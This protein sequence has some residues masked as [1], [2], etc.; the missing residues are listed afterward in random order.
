MSK[1]NNTKQAFWIALGSLF[2]FGFG[3]VS[4]MILSRYFDKADYGT[5]KQV[6]Y[7]YHTLLTVFTLGLPKAFSY[8]LPRVE[9]NQAKNLIKKITNLFFILGAVFSVILFVFAP[10][11][12]IILKNPDLKIALR[13]FSLVP[14]LM[15]PTMGLEGILSTYR[16]TKFMAIY[17]I[18]TRVI[19][20]LC[21]ALPVIIFNLG[22][23]EALIGFTIAS[24]ISF[25]IALYFKYLPVKNTGND[26]CCI[27]YKEIFKFSIPLLY[28]SIWGIIIT[29]ADQFFISRYFGNVVFAEFSNG[30]MEL[31]FVGMIVGATATIL[32]PIFS[33]M[34]HEKLDPQKDIYPI[35]KSVFE[36]SAM[37]IYPLVIYS[38]FFADIIMVALYGNQYVNS[39]IY[40]RIK[41]VVNLFTVIVY[42]PLIINI[43]KVK[44]YS[45]VHMY[46]AIILI[47]LEYFSVLIIES[48]Y[49]LTVISVLCQIGRIFVMLLFV[50][51]YFN[52]KLYRLFPITLILKILIPSVF[53]LLLEYYIIVRFINL[54]VF[55]ALFVSF[56]LYIILYI[57][58]SKIIGLN[59]LSI[60]KPLIKKNK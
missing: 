18:I 2:S 44:F 4:S 59:Y 20:L 24:F 56:F 47:V 60:I 21:V 29:S 30:S 55:V 7:V 42:A 19:M 45:N 27:T 25:I 17:T 37:L 46:G 50:S 36:K 13:I 54:N 11:I 6:I 53:I 15:L 52:I 49:I 57:F 40:F 16:K 26:K 22:Y 28:A 10:Q 33:R 5:Y 31:P 34:S 14:F 23:R 38:W 1:T 3:I 35:W 32:S 12:S 39:S 9:I 8:F 51:K 48:P 43:G 41:L 58:T